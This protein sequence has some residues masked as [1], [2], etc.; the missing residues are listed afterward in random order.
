LTSPISNTKTI[1]DSSA[2]KS[3]TTPLNKNLILGKLYA[4]TPSNAQNDDVSHGSSA[5]ATSSPSTNLLQQ[6]IQKIREQAKNTEYQRTEVEQI[7]RPYGVQTLTRQISNTPS[8][9]LVQVADAKRI[10]APLSGIVNRAKEGLQQQQQHKQPSSAQNQTTQSTNKIDPIDFTIENLLKT[11]SI[12]NKPLFIKDLDFRDLTDMDDIDVTRVVLMNTGGGP[13]P[14]PNFTMMNGGPPPPP[15]PP[16]PPF[17]M[18]GPPPPPPPPP[19]PSQTQFGSTGQ[20]T[21]VK[22]VLPSNGLLSSNNASMSTSTTTNGHREDAHDDNK[23]KLIKLHWKEANLQNPN[24]INTKDET[25]WSNITTIEIDKEKL[26]H[27]FELKQSELKTKV[28]N[29]AQKG[30]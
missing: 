1:Q 28:N 5:D 11:T 24:A 8:D 10:D 14:P 25:I 7:N 13:P 27:L 6:R 19:P 30:S 22:V 16:P 29:Q 3:P 26:S 21:G 12:I 9:L 17:G 20:M 18:A 15:P 23:R 2:C 4:T